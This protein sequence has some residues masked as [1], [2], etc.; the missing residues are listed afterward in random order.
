MPPANCHSRHP[1]LVKLLCAT[2]RALSMALREAALARPSSPVC[3]RYQMSVTPETGVW[4]TTSGAT[5][6][7]VPYWQYWGSPGVSF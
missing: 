5:N 3:Q 6:S 4:L 2:E 1:G 7:G